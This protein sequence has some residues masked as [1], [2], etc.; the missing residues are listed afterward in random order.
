MGTTTKIDLRIDEEKKR[1]IARAAKA[2]RADGNAIRARSR[3]ARRTAADRRRN[4][5]PA[6]SA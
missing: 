2:G 4:P 3:L 5:A 1:V 6:L